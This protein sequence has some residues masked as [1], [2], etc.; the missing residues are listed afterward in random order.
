MVTSSLRSLST[1]HFILKYQTSQQKPNNFLLISSY[2]VTA[3]LSVPC[4]GW[5]SKRT[6]YLVGLVSF[7][8]TI[9]ISPHWCL[10]PIKLPSVRLYGWNSR[11]LL[12]SVYLTFHSFWQDGSTVVTEH[13]LW[14][15]S[16]ASNLGCTV[17]WPWA[18][19]FLTCCL[20]LY[21]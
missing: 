7:S 20:F 19:D 3:I 12:S 13:G 4:T 15:L 17:R 21:L 11:P 14:S 6:L 5:S 8:S 2:P 10:N 18:S 9:Y 16:L 1:T